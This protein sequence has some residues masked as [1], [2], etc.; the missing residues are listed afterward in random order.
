MQQ[1]L[2]KKQALA[3]AINQEWRISNRY[4]ETY[5]WDANGNIKTVKRYGML[6]VRLL[7]TALFKGLT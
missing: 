6:N 2:H 1:K 4:N 7:L 5:T 3:I